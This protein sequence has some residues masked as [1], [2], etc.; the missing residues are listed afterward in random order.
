MGSRFVMREM[1]PQISGQAN[2]YA[3]GRPEYETSAERHRRKL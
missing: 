1:M 3:G 2:S